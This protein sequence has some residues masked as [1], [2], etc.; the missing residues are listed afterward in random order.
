MFGGSG[1][2]VGKGAAEAE[3]EGEGAG[4]AAPA[5]P[6]VAAMLRQNAAATKNAGNRIR[7]N[8]SCPL[9]RP[10]ERCNDRPRVE[11]ANGAGRHA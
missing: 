8:S 11:R 3:A 7:F 9:E 2:A 5:V 10:A 4:L 6:G 1:V